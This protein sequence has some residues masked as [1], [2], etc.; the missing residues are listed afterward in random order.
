MPRTDRFVRW[1]RRVHRI[2]ELLAALLCAALLLLVLLR[3]SHAGNTD[4]PMDARPAGEDAR[5]LRAATRALE[6]GDWDAA[7]GA[8]ASRLAVPEPHHPALRLALGNAL[9]MLGDMR[10]AYDAFAL[11]RGGMPDDPAAARNFALAACGV[12]RWEACAGSF[13][14][15]FAL[16]RPGDPALLRSAAEAW[17]RLGRARE[18]ARVMDAVLPLLPDPDAACLRR[19]AWIQTA[20]GRHGQGVRAFEAALA[21]HPLDTGLWLALA[22]AE[23]AGDRLTHAAAALETALRTSADRNGTEAAGGGALRQ[24]L[25]GLYLRLGLPLAAARLHP[26]P[27][28]P[29]LGEDA[30]LAASLRRSAILYEQAG[31]GNAAF[32][33]WERLVDMLP[34]GEERAR[35]RRDAAL[36]CLRIGRNEDAARLLRAVVAQAP[37]D[38]EARFFLATA[39]LRL[40][41]RAMAVRA[42]EGIPPASAQRPHADRLLDLLR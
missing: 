16:A 12:E 42:L 21:R 37:G 18:A 40:H 15:A 17:M 32:A 26:T 33:A 14:A 41:D 3:A 22:Q 31:L 13:E 24:R 2:G 20:A 23:E 39:A 6:A 10:G 36:C 8:A 30:S 1:P 4:A 27:I 29:R 19:N 28:M 7:R 11:A 35:G 25:A 5:A 38:A 9:Y 34:S